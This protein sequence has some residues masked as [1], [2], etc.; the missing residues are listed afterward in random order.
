MPTSGSNFSAREIDVL[1]LVALGRSDAQIGKELSITTH[2]VSN[3][4]GN[5]LEKLG[6]AN[7]TEAAAIALRRG[8]IPLP[9]ADTSPEE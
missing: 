3:H 4:V 7:R 5:I 1:T 6:A 2:T 9:R 8:I